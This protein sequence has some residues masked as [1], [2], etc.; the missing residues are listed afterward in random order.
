MTVYLLYSVFKQPSGVMTCSEEYQPL[1][2]KGRNNTST[3]DLVTKYG[4]GDPIAGNL[5]Q[6]QWDDYVPQ[7]YAKLAANGQ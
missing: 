2:A 7:L 6:A 3:R 1:I 5:F 4:L